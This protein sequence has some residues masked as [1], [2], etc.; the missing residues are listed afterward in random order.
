MDIFG[1][2]HLESL[3]DDH[4][5]ASLSLILNKKLSCKVKARACCVEVAACRAKLL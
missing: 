1:F 5:I 3:S 4:F 2:S